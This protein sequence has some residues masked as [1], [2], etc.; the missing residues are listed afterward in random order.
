[1][2]TPFVVI[3]TKESPTMP[4]RRPSRKMTSDTAATPSPPHPS[5]GRFEE[6]QLRRCRLLPRSALRQKWL[7]ML[8][9]LR[10]R[11][12]RLPPSRDPRPAPLSG[13]LACLPP[14]DPPSRLSSAES[15]VSFGGVRS[16]ASSAD[17]SAEKLPAVRS[18]AARPALPVFGRR[19]R[20]F[21]P[22][23]AGRRWHLAPVRTPP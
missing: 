3:P 4:R 21:R 13:H 5:R 10:R 18:A 11:N 22:R 7:K 23:P 9:P 20:R 2:T 16:A 1:M 14:F 15:S 17:G 19:R 8:P 6:H 12:R